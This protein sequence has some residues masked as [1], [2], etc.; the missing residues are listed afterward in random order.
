MDKMGVTSG[1]HNLCLEMLQQMAY[2]TSEVGYSDIYARFCTSSKPVVVE[3]YVTETGILFVSSG[4]W[5]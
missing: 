5:E 1:Q 3:Y 2:A 4:L